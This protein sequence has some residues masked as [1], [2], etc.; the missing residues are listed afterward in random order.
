MC[1]I[2]GNVIRLSTIN[3]VENCLISNQLFE[4][5]MKIVQECIKRIS[6]VLNSVVLFDQIF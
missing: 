6:K 3:L 4:F 2:A 1:L 5:F